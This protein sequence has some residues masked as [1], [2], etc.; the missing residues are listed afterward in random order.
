MFLILSMEK[1]LTYGG[2][3][4]T[5]KLVCT[6]DLGPGGGTRGDWEVL[7]GT[8]NCAG[9]TGG[10]ELVGTRCPDGASIVDVWDGR[11]KVQPVLDVEISVPTPLPS[12]GSDPFYASGPAVVR[13]LLP[14]TGSVSTGSITTSPSPLGDRYVTLSMMKYFA[15]AGGTFDVKLVVTLDNWTGSTW[16]DWRILSGTGSYAGLKGNGTLAGTFIPSP[17]SVLD[18]YT[19]HLK[20]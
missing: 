1:Y 11:L 5:V 19:G 4:L 2:G 18:V 8:G 12:T 20:K 6:L 13:G 9:I 14:A 7:G 3:T 15:C 17:Y 16:G 10:G